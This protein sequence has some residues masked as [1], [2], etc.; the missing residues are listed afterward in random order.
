MVKTALHTRTI[1]LTDARATENCPSTISPDSSIQPVET[2]PKESASTIDSF[3]IGSFDL[4]R[5]FVEH[6]VAEHASTVSVDGRSSRH[7]I[8]WKAVEAI[9]AD[10][11][12]LE[13]AIGRAVVIAEQMCRGVFHGTPLGDP[14][15][16]PG[17][18][19]PF[20]AFSMA[21]VVPDFGDESRFRTRVAR[22]VAKP[23]S[24]GTERPWWRW[25]AR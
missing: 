8:D 1:F 23:R 14:P 13:Q 2:L 22:K 16:S 12:S 5:S 24:A 6:V 18:E 21:D 15:P 20:F 11:T 25:P 4:V 9:V 17:E 19:E 3:A 10:S 7:A